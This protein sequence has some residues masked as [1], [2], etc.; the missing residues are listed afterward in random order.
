MHRRMA[1]L[2]N[3]LECLGA[4][5]A[6]EQIMSFLEQSGLVNVL[7]RVILIML[8]FSIENIFYHWQYIYH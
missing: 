5:V 8:L 6:C 2:K 4:D 3:F 1:G 7:Q